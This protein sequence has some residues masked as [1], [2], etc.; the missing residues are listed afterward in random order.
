MITAHQ[1]ATLAIRDSLVRGC[2]IEIRLRADAPR[3][4]SLARVMGALAEDRRS[5]GRAIEYVGACGDR[6]WTVKLALH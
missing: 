3:A 5:V 4:D 1:Q 2:A 6:R